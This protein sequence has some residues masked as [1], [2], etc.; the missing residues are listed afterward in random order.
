MLLEQ[1]TQRQGSSQKKK[2]TDDDARISDIERKYFTTSDYNKFTREIIGAKIKEQ[3]LVDKSNI[4]N[5]V[6]NS[7]LNTK[8][9]KLAT[10]AELK[11]E[12]NKIVKVQTHD[13]NYF[14]G[15]YF[16]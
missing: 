11:V 5:L 9:A 3:G 8:L 13:L 1:D 2:K 7:N 12:Q 6:K 4:S 14:F 15:K 10:K 16:F